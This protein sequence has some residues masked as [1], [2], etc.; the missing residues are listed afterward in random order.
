MYN[1]RYIF[2]LFIFILLSLFQFWGCSGYKRI[3]N[4]NIQSDI[5]NDGIPDYY[6]ACPDVAGKSEFNGCPGNN[7]DVK[8]DQPDEYIALADSLVIADSLAKLL[9]EDIK[10]KKYDTIIVA[11]PKLQDKDGDGINDAFD[12][13]PD[14]F[15]TSNNHG[16]P[17]EYIS[18]DDDSENSDQKKTKNQNITKNVNNS[19]AKINKSEDD[20]Q[21]EKSGIIAY[22]FHKEMF[23]GETKDLWVT[24]GINTTKPQVIKKVREAEAEQMELVEKYDT[25]EAHTIE[26]T[27][28]DSLAIK[29]E[30][31][32]SDFE[33][34]AVKTTEKQKINSASGNR[35]HWMLTAISEKPE[36]TITLIIDGI[37]PTG[38]K[39][40][41]PDKTIPI[42]IKIK[43]RNVVRK[44][45]AYLAE[46]PEYTIPSVI[47]PLLGFFYK[48]WMNRKKKKD[49]KPAD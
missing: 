13:C 49:Q 14:I 7:K 28:F 16:C 12:N 8:L 17:E 38:E 40:D 20:Y 29:I 19:K 6:D 3:P 46:H 44:F 33:I 1:P 47:I 27:V 25:C 26:I 45:I 48:F 15:G 35:W 18:K 37:K 42:E 39:C 23:K 32:R 21:K 2:R 31:D 30:Y 10:Y 5:D 9:L 22:C 36:A 24:L 11:F 43:P 4:I 34:K 41:L